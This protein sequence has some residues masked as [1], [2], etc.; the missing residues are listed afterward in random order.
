MKTLCLPSPWALRRFTEK[1]KIRAGNNGQLLQLL[2]LKAD[3]MLSE[4][5]NVI[6]VD[7]VSIKEFTFSM[8]IKEVHREGK[9]K[10]RK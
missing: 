2:K 1:V 6:C 3:K 10:G 8:G 4:K 9:N 5:K 7:E